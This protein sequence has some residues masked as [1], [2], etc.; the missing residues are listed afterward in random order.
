VDPDTVRD[1]AKKGLG[2]VFPEDSVYLDKD[3]KK[4]R[5]ALYRAVRRAEMEKMP[6]CIAAEG[7]PLVEDVGGIQGYFDFI[8]NIYRGDEEMA[9]SLREWA[10]G[11]GWKG[12][13]GKPENIL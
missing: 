12:I 9:S 1:L 6:S 4:I 10:R 7:L 8:R 2:K 11:L 13:V 3:G 5:G